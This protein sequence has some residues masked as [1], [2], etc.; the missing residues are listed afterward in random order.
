MTVLSTT[1]N[2]SKTTAL[3]D[4]GVDHVL[5]DDGNVAQQVRT[6]LPAGVDTALELV[7]TPTLPDTATPADAHPPVLVPVPVVATYYPPPVPVCRT[8]TVLY[9]TCD[10]E[11]WRAYASYRSD[12][13]ARH[14]AHYLRHTGYHSRVVTG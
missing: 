8:W 14:A 6:I 13:A 5:I 7:G 1:R 12:D 4:G 2:A 3:T 9:R 11:P 10:R